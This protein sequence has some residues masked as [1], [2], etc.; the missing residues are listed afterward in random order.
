LEKDDV[1][2]AR[3]EFQRIAECRYHGQGF[4][5]R[6]P[7]PDVDIVP[8][9]VSKIVEGFHAQHQLDYGY[10]FEDGEVELITIRVIGMERVAPLEVSTLDQANAANTTEEALI[11]H[12]ETVFDDGQSLQTPRYDRNKLRA[13]HVVSGPSIIIQHN[14]TIL[15]PP[16]YVAQTG[17]YGNLTIERSN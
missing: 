2:A 14:S 11:Y 16:G 5:L 15:V 1:P 10:A 4:E 8:E 3:Q 6:A 9:N 7:I 13:G 17:E 12:A